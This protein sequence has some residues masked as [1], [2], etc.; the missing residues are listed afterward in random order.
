MG[1]TGRGWFD[2]RLPFGGAPLTLGWNR[3]DP[4][5][6][7]EG[8]PLTPDAQRRRLGEQPEGAVSKP[9]Q[10]ELLTPPARA[11]P[12]GGGHLKCVAGV[13]ACGQRLVN[14]WS[15]PG[16]EGLKSVVG[17]PTPT[18]APE[19]ARGPQTPRRRRL[20]LEFRVVGLL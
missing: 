14:A 11:S 8:A 13:N 15:T 1:W 20:R 16:G 6:A 4:A 17:F 9:P 12:S 19:H 10:P 3:V 5:P 2:P 18:Q 7:V